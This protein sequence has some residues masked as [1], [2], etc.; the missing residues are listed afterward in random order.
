MPVKEGDGPLLYVVIDAKTELCFYF[1]PGILAAAGT[2]KILLI[3]RV[4]INDENHGTIVWPKDKIGHDYGEE[5][6]A[7][8]PR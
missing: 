1:R 4:P 5:L 7:L 6:K 3:A 8:Y 2:G